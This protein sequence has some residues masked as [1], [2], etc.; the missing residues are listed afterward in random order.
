MNSRILR[1]LDWLVFIG[2]LTIAA[3]VIGAT[4]LAGALLLNWWLS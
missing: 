4:L 3:V 1:G 2:I